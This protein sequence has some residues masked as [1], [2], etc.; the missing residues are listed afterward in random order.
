MNV[1]GA[2]RELRENKK[3][4]LSELAKNS[5]LTKSYLSRIESGERSPTIKSVQSICS[6]LGVSTNTL[7]ILAD[8]ND[9]ELSNKLKDLVKKYL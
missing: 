9:S 3:M 7:F 8:S 2:I 5:G 6:G 1:S 4:T